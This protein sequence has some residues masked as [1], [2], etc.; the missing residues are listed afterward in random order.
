M[1][2][3]I[4]FRINCCGSISVRGKWVACCSVAKSRITNCN[5]MDYS[6]PGFAVLHYLQ[7]SA[8]TH[9]HWIGDAIQSSLPLLPPFPPALNLSQH[10]SLFQWIGF[11]QQV[12]KVLEL[13]LQHQFFI[14]SNQNSFPLG[15][16]GLIS[17]QSKGFSWVFSNTT[18]Q[19]HQF[20]FMV[21]T[22]IRDC[23][24]NHSFD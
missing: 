3:L 4:S 5:P 1:T 13:Q 23:W 16:T 8:Q 11:S 19:T 15:L 14:M 12:A 24:K 2:E 7:E 18:V 20:F 22:S 6:M 21:D 10:W 17:L 9:V